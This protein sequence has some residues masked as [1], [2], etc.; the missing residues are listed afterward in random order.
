MGLGYGV[1]A[2]Q[3]SPCCDLPIMPARRCQCALAENI[4]SRISKP[5]TAGMPNILQNSVLIALLV[6]TVDAGAAQSVTLPGWVCTHP[7]A[8]FINGFEIGSVAVPQLHS[9][10]SGGAHPG[11]ITR[12]VAVTGLGL[13]TY[14]LYVP[15][16][17]AAN[18]AWPLIVVLHGAGG[19]GT[20]AS[21]AQQVRTDWGSLADARGF[22]IASP[23]GTNSNGGWNEPDIN[24]VGPSDYDIIANTI[25]D[26][27]SAY[28]IDLARVHGWGYSAGGE[29]LYDIVLTGWSGLNA[30]SFAAYAV[31]GAAL[32]GCPPYN[33]VQ[34]CVPANAARI[35]PLDIHI[36]MADSIYTGGYTASDKNA[37][38][39]AGWTT[40]TTLFYTVFTD[41]SPAGGHTY[42]IANLAQVWS[43]LCPKAVTP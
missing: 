18:Q 31:T 33:T 20:S 35:I 43:N 38:L 9:N 30:N 2:V 25:S 27:K 34:S 32:A 14:Y 29:V 4:G 10:G 16:A 40:G 8:I 1:M 13:Q 36:G 26:V 3:R 7:D 17:Y 24:G 39:A 22:I 12:Q 21:A 41:G 6:A 15:S 23:V 42:S 37:F 28:N 11:N 19:P 5:Y